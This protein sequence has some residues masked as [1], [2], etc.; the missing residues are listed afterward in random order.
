MTSK[1]QYSLKGKNRQEHLGI[2]S[3]NFG[4]SE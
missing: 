4:W 3:P 1:M 2:A